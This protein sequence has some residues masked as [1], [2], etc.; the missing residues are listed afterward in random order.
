MFC[1]KGEGGQKR[2][3]AGQVFVSRWN[4]DSSVTDRELHKESAEAAEASQRR[5]DWAVH[6]KWKAGGW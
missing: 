1:A 5:E 3:K 6:R 2:A 4:G